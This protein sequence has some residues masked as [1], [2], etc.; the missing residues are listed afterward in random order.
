MDKSSFC[1]SIK[2]CVQTPNIHAKFWHKN[3][4]YI[5]ASIVGL[6]QVYPRS[7]SVGQPNTNCDSLFNEISYFK[8]VMCKG[9]EDDT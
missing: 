8:A 3:S 4:V 2:T 6:G 1:V 7:L 5:N 9:I